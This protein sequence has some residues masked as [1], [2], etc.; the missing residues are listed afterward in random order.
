MGWE[1]VR[2]PSSISQSSGI[3]GRDGL[4]TDKGTAPLPAIFMAP[5]PA[6]VKK[7]MPYDQRFPNKRMLGL[8]AVQ[9]A[10]AIM[11]IITQVIISGPWRIHVIETADLWCGVLFAASGFLGVIA[12]TR[13]SFGSIVTF[14]VFAII[15]AAFCFAVLV[16]GNVSWHGGPGIYNG[17]CAALIIQVIVG[18]IQAAAAIIA[19]GMTCGAAWNCTGSIGE[20]GV[21]CYNGRGRID[22]KNVI[23][24][25][26]T[27]PE[28]P[29]GYITITISQMQAD[30]VSVDA[31]AFQ[32]IKMIRGNTKIDAADKSPPPKYDSVPKMEEDQEDANLSQ[33][34]RF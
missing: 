27:V 5:T 28:Q 6:P 22:T 24:Q 17:M 32:N 33:Y 14:M 11:A 29:P 16:S 23:D 2:M 34:Q 15:S 31:T 20:S 21:V 1:D 8:S 19:A 12:S 13:P 10:M 18:V 4:V 9:L 7:K 3:Q 26:I 25:H 30:A